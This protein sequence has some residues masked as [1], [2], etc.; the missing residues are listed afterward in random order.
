MKM[1][2]GRPSRAVPA[3]VVILVGCLASPGWTQER[4]D[5]P[6]APDE[7]TVEELS[8][9]PRLLLRGFGNID[10][11]YEDGELPNT[12][13]LGQ[14]DLFMTSEL[15]DDV[16]VLAEIVFEGKP[17]E[18]ERTIDVERYE[19][20]YSPHDAFNVA[21]GRMHT[22]LGFWNQTYHHGT[23]FQTTAARP[24]IY[25]FEDESG[26][27]PIH[28]VGLRIFGAQ[29]LPG[30][31]LHY[32]ASISNGRAANA[33]DVIT[34]QDPNDHKAVNLWLGISPKAVPGLQFGGVFHGDRIPPDP[35][36]PRRENE[37]TERIWGGFAVYQKAPLELL[38]EAFKIRHQDRVTSEV[39][40]TTGL[41]AQAA[42]AVGKFKPYYR[43]DRVR[44]VGKDP[45]YPTSVRDASKH[46]LGVRFDPRDRLAL[47]LDLSRDR[48]HPGATI[49]AVALQAAVTF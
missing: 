46:T 18:E 29:S 11:R 48:P 22:V 21:L 30:L 2:P 24:E 31:R 41:Y 14:L 8:P 13:V 36:R 25:R 33:S 40:D 7:A 32:A 15:A 43:Y 34:V 27:L 1:L 47:K 26:V 3:A 45:Y 39:F 5:V 42:Y 12:F 35:T 4:H 17:G 16:S 49:N 19:M 20:K 9:P 23:W 28:E 38:S 37:M 10:Y 44:G 6:P